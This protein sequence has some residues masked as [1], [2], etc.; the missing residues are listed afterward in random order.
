MA[1]VNPQAIRAIT[2]NAAARPNIPIANVL[3]SILPR[4]AIGAINRFRAIAVSNMPTPPTPPAI[5]AACPNTI[6]PIATANRPTLRVFQSISPNAL[7]G[8]TS[9]FTAR[10]TIAIPIPDRSRSPPFITRAKPAKPASTAPTTTSPLNKIPGSISDILSIALTITITA[11]AVITKAAAVPIPRAADLVFSKNVASANMIAPIA[12]TA[13]NN[14]TESISARLSRAPAIILTAIARPIIKA[15]LVATPVPSDDI[16]LIAPVSA[17]TIVTRAAEALINCPESIPDIILRAPA[18]M[19]VAAAKPPIISARFRASPRLK[20]MADNPFI[21]A[22]IPPIPSVNAPKALDMFSG[23]MSSSNLIDSANIPIAMAIEITVAGLIAST[24]PLK[25]LA[26]DLRASP[27]SLAGLVTP[28]ILSLMASNILAIFLPNRINPAIAP[29]FRISSNVNS[30]NISQ[31]APTT[32]LTNKNTTPKC[33]HNQLPAFLAPLPIVVKNVVMS[34]VVVLTVSFKSV[35]L[36]FDFSENSFIASAAFPAM[37]AII[38]S[39]PCSHST[40]ISPALTK[41]FLESS[42]RFLNHFEA[43]P[44][45]STISGH[46]AV[47][48]SEV[49]PKNSLRASLVFPNASL[50]TSIAGWNFSTTWATNS[51]NA[52]IMFTTY[53]VH[54]GAIFFSQSV[55]VLIKLDSPVSIDSSQPLITSAQL[56][57][58]PLTSSISLPNPNASPIPLKKSW[59]TPIR[60]DSATDTLTRNAIKFRG[61]IRNRTSATPPT[62][63]RPAFRMLKNKIIIGASISPIRSIKCATSAEKKYNP[64]A[65]LA[66]VSTLESLKTFLNDRHR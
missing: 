46:Q 11:T 52:I 27:P 28:R 7:I 44:S 16:V 15:V 54:I 51:F 62:I 25:L 13:V 60:S 64:S 33:S 29:P 2:P 42:Y 39:G 6:T 47:T 34:S 43:I 4:I 35:I 9:R 5:Q 18:N 50:R 49:A 20:S 17:I 23:S 32:S 56:S 38:S 57:I 45:A 65:S 3:R 8:A 63:L 55:P 53:S 61:N 24:I 12:A 31:T 19:I 59:T 1:A 40:I 22:Y 14:L 66:T 48:N 26:I 21:I 36:A 37:S 10:A 30:R 58:F 41:Y